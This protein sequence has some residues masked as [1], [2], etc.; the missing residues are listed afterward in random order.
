VIR[1]F[2]KHLKPRSAARRSFLRAVGAGAAA[3]PF[4]P[5]LEDSFAQSVG[6]ALPLKL[7]DISAPHGVAY[8]YFAMRTPESPD[9]AVDALSTRGSDT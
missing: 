8:E 3:W 7:L 1:P 9:I 5:L 6:D 4:Y 2:V